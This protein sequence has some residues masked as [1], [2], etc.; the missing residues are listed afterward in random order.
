MGID[1]HIHTKFS[2]GTLSPEQVVNKAIQ[3]NLSAIAITD[4]DTT[5]GIYPALKKAKSTSLE[6]IPGIELSTHYSEQEVHILGY[7]FDYQGAYINNILKKLQQKRVD[8]AKKIVEKLNQLGIE[9]SYE[10]VR[11]IASGP[12]IGRPHIAEAMIEKHY[13]NSMKEA[14]DKFIGEDAPAYV[15]RAKLTPFEAINIIKQANGIP[16]LAHP[17]LLKDQSIIYDLIDNGI[18]GLEVYHSKHDENQTEYYI[19]VASENGLLMTGGSDSHGEEPLL[20]G[21]ISV[22]DKVLSELKKSRK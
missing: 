15:H 3:L 13:V 22:P 8:R 18:M 4:H 20:L 14:F 10:R 1:L 16:V 21:T 6:V 11:T 17:G 12:S 9:I 19:K 5:E 7:Y 2:D